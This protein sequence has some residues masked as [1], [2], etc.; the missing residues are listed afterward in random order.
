MGLF[1]LGLMYRLMMM[2]Y[3]EDWY[4][5]GE[6]LLRRNLTNNHPIISKYILYWVPVKF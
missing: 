2:L 4:N 5:D 1:G 6:A 3:G